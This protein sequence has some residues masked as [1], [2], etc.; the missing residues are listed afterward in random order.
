MGGL[1]FARMELSTNWTSGEVDSGAYNGINPGAVSGHF[2]NPLHSLEMATTDLL[3]GLAVYPGGG[4][5]IRLE[6]F[7]L[8]GNLLAVD[9]I[10]DDGLI[11]AAVSGIASFSL[12][13]VTEMEDVLGYDDIVFNDVVAETVP[14][15]GLILLRA[16]GLFGLGMIRRHIA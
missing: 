15:P 16:S 5:A 14:E 4:S 9:E 2:V 6:V 8:M 13:H 1:G 10:Y 12:Y 7:G 11:S 3:Q